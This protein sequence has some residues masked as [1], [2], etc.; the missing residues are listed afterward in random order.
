MRGCCQCVCP[1]GQ[2]ERPRRG[3]HTACGGFHHTAAATWAAALPPARPNVLKWARLRNA[4]GKLLKEENKTRRL[5][6]LRCVPLASHQDFKGFAP[7]WLRDSRLC[8]FCPHPQASPCRVTMSEKLLPQ[9]GSFTDW[10][11][12]VIREGTA[13]RFMWLQHKSTAF[14]TGSWKTW[15]KSRGFFSSLFFIVPFQ[16]KMQKTKSFSAVCKDFVL[17]K[18][19]FLNPFESLTMSDI[20]YLFFRITGY[21]RGKGLGGLTVSFW[22][23]RHVFVMGPSGCFRSSQTFALTCW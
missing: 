10:R 2:Q 17:W 16:L 6:I 19:P 18:V 15:I 12:L 7:V 4:R 3:R 20:L 8:Q 5:V 11:L 9:S 23:L 14:G 13:T 21:F 22:F 1:K